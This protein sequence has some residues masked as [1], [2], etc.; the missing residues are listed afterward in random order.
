MRSE[1]IFGA[2]DIRF[3]PFPAYQA[4]FKGN[5]HFPQAKYP[6]RGHGE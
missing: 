5:T 2:N 3:K 6:H 4:C 1:L